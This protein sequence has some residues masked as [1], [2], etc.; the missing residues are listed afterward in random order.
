MADGSDG[1][2]STLQHLNSP[3]IAGE[4]A[5]VVFAGGYG[6]G[7]APTGI[8]L[9]VDQ[10]RRQPQ[11]SPQGLFER[12]VVAAVGI[13]DIWEF[14][15]LDKVYKRLAPNRLPGFN[16][17]VLPI[18][19][20]TQRITFDLWLHVALLADSLIVAGN[21]TLVNGD[22]AGAR[23]VRNVKWPTTTM[24]T[25][26]RPSVVASGTSASSTRIRERPRAAR[27]R[28]KVDDIVLVAL[29]VAA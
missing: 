19:A 28:D 20:S 10:S 25:T 8:E 27:P 5:V 1:F 17:N 2:R 22:L 21:K 13:F 9:V 23:P 11:T 16:V 18:V 4:M 15:G 29:A 26:A 6:P 14:S 7:S 12:V 3:L 24:P